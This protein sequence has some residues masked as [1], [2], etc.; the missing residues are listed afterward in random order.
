M[1]PAVVPYM[2]SVTVQWVVL[3]MPTVQWA[4][5]SMPQKMSRNVKATPRSRGHSN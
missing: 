2:K 5:V 1:P 3:S 4:D